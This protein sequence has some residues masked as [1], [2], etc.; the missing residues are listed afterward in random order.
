MADLRGKSAPA[1]AAAS[2]ASVR[3]RLQQVATWGSAGVEDVVRGVSEEGPLKKKELFMA[4]RLAITGRAV[5]TPLFETMAV[6]GREAS[7]RRLAAAISALAVSP[8]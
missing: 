1:E 6:V 3:A 5:S 7:D 4:L 2:L 8:A